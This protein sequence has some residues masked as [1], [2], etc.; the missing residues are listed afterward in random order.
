MA[1][2]AEVLLGDWLWDG[3]QLGLSTYI[4]IR[5]TDSAPLISDFGP[6][7]GFLLRLLVFILF[8]LR[9][10]S[11]RL[12]GFLAESQMHLYFC[13]LLLRGEHRGANWGLWA[14]PWHINPELLITCLIFPFDM[15]KDV[16]FTLLPFALLS[17]H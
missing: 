15:V 13:D 5:L 2:A 10:W 6:R 12:G 3:L 11:H 16:I 1:A 17:S 8:N 4:S 9:G 14:K 7:Y